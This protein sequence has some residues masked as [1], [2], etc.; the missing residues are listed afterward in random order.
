MQEKKYSIKE[1]KKIWSYVD[2]LKNGISISCAEDFYDW[3]ELNP[4]KVEEII[5]E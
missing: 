5:N 3:I 4:K 1:L 2:D